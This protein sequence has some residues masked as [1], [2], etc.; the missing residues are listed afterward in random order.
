MIPRE[1][2]STVAF[3]TPTHKSNPI[4]DSARI[5]IAGGDAASG[6]PPFREQDGERLGVARRPAVIDRAIA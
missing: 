4:A 2:W 6:R 1:R 5:T 3:A